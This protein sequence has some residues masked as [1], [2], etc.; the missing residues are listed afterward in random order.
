[1]KITPVHCGSYEFAQTA[2]Q[3][4]ERGYVL[5]SFF[6]LEYMRL[7]TASGQ[8]MYSLRKP[9]YPYLQLLPGNFRI[10]F[11][12]S[13]QRKNWVA[14][15]DMEGVYWQEETREVVIDCDDCRLNVPIV[16]PLTMQRA[17]KLEG[18]FQR[19]TRL[20]QQQ[21]PLNLFAAR[22][23]TTSLLAEFSCDTVDPG[24]TDPVQRFKNA[25]DADRE[26]RQTLEELNAGTGLS[27][28]H[29]RRLFVRQFLIDPG[30]Y[31]ARGRLQRIL[32]LFLQT[33]LT[34]KEIAA[35]VGMCHVT[36]L[37]RFLARHMGVS[38]GEIRR[39]Y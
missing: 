16:L 20:L 4:A 27:L 25:I 29:I 6:G 14:I 21:T 19:I 13:G 3:H 31:R 26:Y 38:P 15:C 10:D 36:Y 17:L 37:H 24:V 32:D 34:P 1:M 11:S 23:L 28:G 30:E 33:E 35:Q 8:L 7:Y 9:D 18:V 5:L 2:S 22:Q 39:R 12:Y